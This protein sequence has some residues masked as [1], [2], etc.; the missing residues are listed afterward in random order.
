MI[1]KKQIT[2][3]EQDPEKWDGRE[4]DFFILSLEVKDMLDSIQMEN[5][6]TVT[7]IDFREIQG[8]MYGIIKWEYTINE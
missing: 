8:K 1:T 2:V 5:N 3:V 4:Q 6:Q 7:D